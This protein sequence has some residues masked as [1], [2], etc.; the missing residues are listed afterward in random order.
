[1][2]TPA[3]RVSTFTRHRSWTK[4]IAVNK[5]YFCDKKWLDASVRKAY[6]R[7]TEAYQNSATLFKWQQT[8]C[9]RGPLTCLANSM[10]RYTTK[11]DETGAFPL[12]PKLELCVMTLHRAAMGTSGRGNN[13]RRL[14]YS[15]WWRQQELVRLIMKYMFTFCGKF[16]SRPLQ[17][18]VYNQN[19]LHRRHV[20]SVDIKN[21]TPLYA[22]SHQVVHC[23]PSQIRKYDMDIVQWTPSY[24]EFYYIKIR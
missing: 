20:W 24:F 21:D 15:K 12:P 8:T 6:H 17:I 14:I 22:I 7:C 9:I 3:Q 5:C 4:R 16:R 18:S 1:M 19:N 11:P 13:L 2:V 23:L 10:S